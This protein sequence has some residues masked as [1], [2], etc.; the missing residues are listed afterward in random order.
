MADILQAGN[1][2]Q[3]ISMNISLSGTNI[4]QVGNQTAEYAIRA[5]AGGSVGIS[6][7]DGTSALDRALLPIK[8]PI[9]SLIM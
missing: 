7:Y 5:S 1:A 8:L 3:N 9:L 4:F 2:N 6:T